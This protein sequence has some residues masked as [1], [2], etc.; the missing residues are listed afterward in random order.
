MVNNH[1]LKPEVFEVNR[2]VKTT[3]ISNNAM[4]SW[5]LT[6]GVGSRYSASNIDYTYIGI[7]SRSIG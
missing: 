4:Y 5:L 2:T 7:C 6:V 1:G 3:K